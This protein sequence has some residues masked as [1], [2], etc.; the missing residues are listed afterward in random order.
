MYVT[1]RTEACAHAENALSLELKLEFFVLEDKKVIILLFHLSNSKH[2]RPENPGSPSLFASVLGHTH[3][4][5]LCMLEAGVGF[6]ECFVGH[7]S[8]LLL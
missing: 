1:K 5:F 2:T 8:M 4:T 6:D 3:S 7:A